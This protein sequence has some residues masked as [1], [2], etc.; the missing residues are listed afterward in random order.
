VVKPGQR[1]APVATAS[2][3]GSRRG[4]GVG[5]R[6]EVSVLIS[7]RTIL[8]AAVA[9]ALGA[10]LASIRSVLLLIFVS[11]FSVAVLSPLATG[12]ERRRL[13][14]SWPLCSTVLVL[15]VET[16]SGCSRRWSRMARC[17]RP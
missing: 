12:M 9:V 13:G 16:S 2:G 11:V 10:A 17:I 3:E 15:P 14:W 5:G 8:L 1:E 4:A 7:I 6:R